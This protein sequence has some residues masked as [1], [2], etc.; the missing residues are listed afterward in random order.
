MHIKPR[1]IILLGI[2]ALMTC[3]SKRG[4]EAEGQVFIVTEGRENVKMGLTPI[5]VIPDAEFKTIA[6]VLMSWMEAR[7]QA[8]AQL[9]ADADYRTSFIREIIEMEEAAD[10]EIP[11]LGEIRSDI[12][13][14]TNGAEDLLNSAPAGSVFA[15][16]KRKLIDAAPLAAITSDADGRFKIQLSSKAWLVAYGE[17][18]V[19]YGREDYFWIAP[20]DPAEIK[21]NHQVFL[22][23]NS[24]IESD[25]ALYS[26]LGLACGKTDSLEDFRSVQ[27]SP[28]ILALVD[29][30]TTKARQAKAKA[31]QEAADLKA[32]TEREAKEAYVTACDRL[33]KPMIDFYSRPA[34]RMRYRQNSIGDLVSRG[35]KII[36]WGG[37][38]SGSGSQSSRVADV[39]EEE[40]DFVAVSSGND[41][42]LALSRNGSVSAWG[43][44][45]PFEPFQGT[46]ISPAKLKDVV[47]I[48][49]G[50]RHFAITKEGGIL[51]WGSNIGYENTIPLEARGMKSIAS[52]GYHAIGLKDDGVVSV[53]GENSYGTQHVPTIED[54]VIA[55]D[56]GY[57]HCLA[58]TKD[59]KVIAWGNNY[60]GNCNV[61]I[62]L[63]GVI[64]IAA[65][66]YFNIALKRDGRIVAWGDNEYGQ[67]N[68][69]ESATNVVAISAGLYHGVALRKD[70]VVV[71]WGSNEDGQCKIP[72]GLGDVVAI[73]AGERSTFAIV[74]N[75]SSR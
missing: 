56:A 22:S 29:R 53:F 1:H 9:Q 73:E 30:F 33:R 20:V 3:C 45:S 70:G 57:E 65:G 27:V 64:A 55:V 49:A 11:A 18:S 23:N 39:P 66:Q 51:D 60:S 54:E 50:G 41:V 24:N 17:R 6:Q 69:P 52:G 21:Q 71:C 14:Q 16:A 67:C 25:D 58:L 63:D 36:G 75:G 35:G 72:A 42:T 37:F 74:L 8:E 5:H 44:D 61:P 13:I 47:G 4:K 40:S 48:A 10:V 7:V 59:G 34:N 19:G 15:Q 28:E 68:I 2:I 12:V 62:N 46:S 38:F 43:D 31:E 32:R 26:L